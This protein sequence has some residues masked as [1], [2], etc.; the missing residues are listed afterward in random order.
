MFLSGFLSSFIVFSFLLLTILYTNCTLFVM[1]Y[2]STFYFDYIIMCASFKLFD[3]KKP[4]SDIIRD[5]SFI[6]GGGMI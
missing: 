1:L 4:R 3:Q 5:L 6:T 2:Y